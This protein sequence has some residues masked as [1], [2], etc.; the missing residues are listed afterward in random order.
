ML[1]QLTKSLWIDTSKISFINSERM[2]Y[3]G[4]AQE[5]AFIV[6]DGQKMQINELE[7][8]QIISA[9]ELP[10]HVLTEIPEDET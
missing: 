7:L 1:L 4:I 2:L 8:A 6:V 5:K 9:I 10:T 3:G